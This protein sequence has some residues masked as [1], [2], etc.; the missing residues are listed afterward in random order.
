MFGRLESTHLL[1]ESPVEIYLESDNMH[2]MEQC[3]T[4]KF[5][6]EWQKLH[7][8]INRVRIYRESLVVDACCCICDIA[9]TVGIDIACGLNITSFSSEL[10]RGGSISKRNIVSNVLFSCILVFCNC[11]VLNMTLS[12]SFGWLFVGCLFGCLKPVVIIGN[13]IGIPWNSAFGLGS[14]VR[15]RT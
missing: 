6:S 10:R 15:T 1:R 2:N 11:I 14:W 4:K 12:S 13:S 9:E 8:T 3:T 7:R 5:I